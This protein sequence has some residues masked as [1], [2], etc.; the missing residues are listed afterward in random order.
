MNHLG[1]GVLR[2]VT[3]SLMLGA[4]LFAGSFVQTNLVSDL[5][6]AA[7]TDSNLKNPWGMAFGPTTPF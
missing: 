4:G 2:L 5:P 3:I 1:R 7:Y 6:G